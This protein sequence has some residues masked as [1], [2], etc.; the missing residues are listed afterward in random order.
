MFA[1]MATLKGVKIA[2]HA[3]ESKLN[4]EGQ[5]RRGNVVGTAANLLGQGSKGHGVGGLA[6]KVLKG[7]ELIL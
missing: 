6:G 2:H 4:P 7:A 1:T 3:I 5:Q